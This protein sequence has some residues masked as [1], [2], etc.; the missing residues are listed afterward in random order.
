M[1]ST[2]SGETTDTT[3]EKK[4]LNSD[5]ENIKKTIEKMS[6]NHHIEIANILKSNNILLNENN[7]GIFINLS[8][9]SNSVVKSLE[10]YINFVDNQNNILIQDEKIKTKIENTYFNNIKD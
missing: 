3:S 7:N 2:E 1:I 8:N 9:L 6:K 5:L 10:D 4:Y